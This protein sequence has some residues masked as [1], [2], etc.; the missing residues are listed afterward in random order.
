MNIKK[1]ETPKTPNVTAT[2]KLR[3]KKAVIGNES[4]GINSGSA[5]QTITQSYATPIKPGLKPKNK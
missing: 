2:E 3:E 5:H 4:H 1:P